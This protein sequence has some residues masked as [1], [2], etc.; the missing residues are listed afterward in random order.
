MGDNVWF[1][2]SQADLNSSGFNG[3]PF[4]IQEESDSSKVGDGTMCPVGLTLPQLAEFYWR[5][6]E[7]TV[8]SSGY[9]CL[10]FGGRGADGYK[11]TIWYPDAAI[12][13]SREL[14]LVSK[15]DWLASVGLQWENVAADLNTIFGGSPSEWDRLSFIASF[16]IKLFN[17]V[18]FEG[19]YYPVVSFAMLV[20]MGFIYVIPDYEGAPPPGWIGPTD[21]SFVLSTS[22]KSSY[23]PSYP[24]GRYGATLK[25]TIGGVN[26]DLPMYWEEP[27]FGIE[28][29]GD[30]VLTPRKYWPY[31]NSA[32]L[33][34]WDTAT[35]EQLNDPTS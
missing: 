21:G 29:S 2:T 23:D 35:G 24:D 11:N 19:R 25:V 27:S 26:F 13:I 5:V 33:P 1:A 3:F 31:K 6:K 8:D 17:A 30:I 32:G 4:A 34:V 14:D 12:N 10:G 15:A 7:Y 22:D 9:S 28:S 18:R 16:S 20:Y